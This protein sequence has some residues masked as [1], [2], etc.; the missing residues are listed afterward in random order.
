MTLEPRYGGTCCPQHRYSGLIADPLMKAGMPPK[1]H[2]TKSNNAD[3][4]GDG[5]AGKG[6]VRNN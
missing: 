3:S 5:M 2:E 4:D 6:E 1:N